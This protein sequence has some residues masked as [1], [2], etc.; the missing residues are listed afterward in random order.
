M[1]IFFLLDFNLFA[2]THVDNLVQFV[3]QND[4]VLEVKIAGKSLD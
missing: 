3:D 2:F 1:D 4:K